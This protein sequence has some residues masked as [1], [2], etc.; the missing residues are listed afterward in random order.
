VYIVNLKW[1]AIFLGSFKRLVKL[2]DGKTLLVR[3]AVEADALEL[4]R[5]FKKVTAETDFLVTKPEEVSMSVEQEKAIIRAH[6]EKENSIF[7]VA[8]L[9][10][11]IV[12]SL[13]FIGGGRKR[14]KHKGELGMSVL[15]DF[16][17]LGIGSALLQSLLDWAKNSG[18]K[19]IQ[20]EVMVDNEQ[21]IGLY[22][23]FR[24]KIEGKKEKAVFKN[25]NYV[26]LLIMGRWVE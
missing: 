8:V 23:K 1:G 10:E 9:N 12:G 24:F 11:R 3:N 19:K 25:S 18:I 5:Y 20:L 22:K 13:N 14:T 15:K 2:K 6:L 17:G 21:A 26:D 7:L 16:W 4:I